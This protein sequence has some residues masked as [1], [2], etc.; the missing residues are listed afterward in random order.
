MANACCRQSSSAGEQHGRSS[1]AVLCI[2]RYALVWLVKILLFV[3][4]SYSWVVVV[5]L[6]DVK[7]TNFASASSL[8]GRAP[9]CARTTQT[10]ATAVDAVQQR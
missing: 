5:V 7:V 1:S 3:K 6:N 9:P 2:S 10:D 4:G 8:Q